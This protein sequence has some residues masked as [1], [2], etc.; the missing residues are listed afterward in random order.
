M[1]PIVVVESSRWDHIITCINRRGSTF[2]PTS[3]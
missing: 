3:I 2:P 1:I